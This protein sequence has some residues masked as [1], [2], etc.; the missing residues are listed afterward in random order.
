MIRSLLLASTL[1]A[2]PACKA[3]TDEAVPDTTVMSKTA[4]THPGMVA[5]ANPYAV[6][7]GLA[8]LREGGS[9]VDAAVAVQAALGLVEP[10]SSGLGGGAF[11]MVYDASTGEVWN[12][13][14]REEAPSNVDDTLFQDEDDNPIRYFD[15]IV[16]GRSTGTPGAMVMLGEAHAAYGTL[17]WADLFTPVIPL[18]E[19]GFT[20]SPRM[21]SLL[22]RMQSFGSPLDKDTEAGPLWFP[23]G[24]ALTEGTTLQNLAY[25][26]T[27][28]ALQDNPRALVEGPIAASIAAKIAEEPRPGT[29]T[30]EDMA[31]YEAIRRPALCGDYRGY[32]ICGARPPASGGVA[33]LNALGILETFDMAAQFENDTLTTQGWHIFIEASRLAYADRDANVSAPETMGVTLEQLLNADYLKSRASLI[34]MDSTIPTAQ[35]GL[36]GCNDATPDSPGTSHLTIVDKDGLTVSMTT[37]VE[38]AF[39]SQR[40]TNGF[41]LNNQLTDF[42]FRS[43]DANGCAIPNRVGPG[44][45]PRSSMSP[46]IVFDPNGEFLFTTGSPG[47]NSII[48]YTLKSIVGVIDGGLSP[49]EAANLPNVIGRGDVTSIEKDSMDEATL[50]ALRDLGHELRTDRGEI[51]GI[52]MI[53][54]QADGTLIGAADTRREGVARAASAE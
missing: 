34:K 14:G 9:A 22:G 31:S 6:D 21:S 28:R 32:T 47:G 27:L 3:Q 26:D 48:A 7:A 29:L 8:I 4:A 5:A 51:S 17:D 24:E 2:L 53:Q 38:G 42:S 44:K 30:I 20:V 10:Q 49:Q 45:R 16:S 50:T 36:G 39:G 23:N 13:D 37:T 15:G 40:M 11:L 46:T 41:V 25:A 1:L 33:I 43:V 19:D 12:Y 52:H 35:P 18:A 54:R